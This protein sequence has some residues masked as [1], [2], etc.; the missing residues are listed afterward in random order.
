ML[1]LLRD[2][3]GNVASINVMR[4]INLLVNV[5]GRLEFFLLLVCRTVVVD[6]D[7]LA[8]QGV[9]V[10]ETASLRL[11]AHEEDEEPVQNRW[12]D[13]HEEELPLDLVQS[14]RACDEDDDVSEVEAH[15]AE[16][17]A[18]AADVGWEDLGAGRCV[19]LY[20]YLNDDRGTYT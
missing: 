4:L 17:C 19:S 20:S 7:L 18:L 8:E 10:L 2:N 1:H 3:F 14:D 13:Q 12:T 16:A 9:D 6:G 15:H 5:N 11:W